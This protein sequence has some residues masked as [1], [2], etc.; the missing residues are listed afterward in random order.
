MRAMQPHLPDETVAVHV[1]VILRQVDTERSAVRL[2][3]YGQ[4]PCRRRLP[5]YFQ[6]VPQLFRWPVCAYHA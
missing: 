4:G 1:Q 6:H 3:R 5:T 2:A